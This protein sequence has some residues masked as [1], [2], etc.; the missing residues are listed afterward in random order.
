MGYNQRFYGFDV[1]SIF[2]LILTCILNIWPKTRILG[3]LILVIVIFRAFSKE[4]YKRENENTKFCNSVNKVL[5]KLGLSLP[6]NFRTLN[7]FDLGMFYKLKNNIEQFKKYKKVTCPGCHKKLMLPRGR[8]KVIITC[9]KCSTE[10]KA[11]V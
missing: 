8:G 10:F 5:G 3:T 2:L 11:K 4:F 7:T 1:L 9:K 6:S